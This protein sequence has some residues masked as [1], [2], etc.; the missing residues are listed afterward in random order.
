MKAA[1]VKWITRAI[2]ESPYCIG[3]CVDEPTFHREL[4][5]LKIPREHWPE[6]LSGNKHARV[7]SFEKDGG[8]DLCCI[9]CIGYDKKRD[10]NQVIGLIVHEAVH[11][12]QYICAD[13]GETEV[14]LQRNRRSLRSNYARFVVAPQ[15]RQIPESMARS[16]VLSVA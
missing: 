12:W 6:W 1:R 3:I 10:P 8:R 11:I 9:V 14:L 15:R 16:G 13:I 5:R 4:R 7:H 2:V